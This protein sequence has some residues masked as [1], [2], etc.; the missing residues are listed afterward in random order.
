MTRPIKDEFL[1]RTDISRQRRYQLR[2]ARDGRCKSCGKRLPR[3]KPTGGTGSTIFCEAC[4]ERRNA[5]LRKGVVK[6]LLA[7]P[8]FPAPAIAVNWIY[9]AKAVRVVDGDT[10]DADV[11]VGFHFTSRQRLRLARVDAAEMNSRDPDERTR[12]AHTKEIVRLMVTDREI[13]IKTSTSRIAADLLPQCFCDASRV[14]A[15]SSA[16]GRVIVMAVD[17]LSLTRRMVS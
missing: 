13:L 14:R 15:R 1:E 3:R 17:S 2:K 7:A 5:R 4:R 10:I 16:A 6:S 11:D 9:G 12:A 8:T